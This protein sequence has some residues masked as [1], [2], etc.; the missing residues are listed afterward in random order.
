MRT[1]VAIDLNPEIKASLSS[2]VRS[3][4]QT[5]AEVKWVGEPSFHL[6][7]KFLGEIAAK[8][9]EPIVSAMEAEAR[10]SAPFYL[11]CRSTGH[12]P[13]KGSP[14]VIWAGVVPSPELMDLQRR[15]EIAFEKLGFPR[16]ARDFHPHLTLGRVKSSRHLE[17]VLRLLKQ[18]EDK[19]FGQMEVKA[20]TLFESILRPE[21]AE[22]RVI[23]E[24]KL[25]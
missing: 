16:E 6:T 23:K 22:Y 24:V 5:K 18:Y 20:L 15:L 21:G 7:L 13:K 17:T 12:F 9:L 2:L 11:E 4:R 8:D 19:S 3:L 10:K 1:F 14:R 25:G